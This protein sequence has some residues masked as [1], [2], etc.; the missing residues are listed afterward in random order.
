MKIGIL[1][2]FLPEKRVSLLP[3][4]CVNLIK[5][6]AEVWI[7]KD[8]GVSAF[9]SNQDYEKLGVKIVSREELLNSADLIVGI[10][11]PA[12]ADISLL[13]SSQVLIAAMNVSTTPGLLESLLSSGSTSFS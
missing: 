2:E 12:A 9:A 8:A 11:T 6:K 3:E 13:K 10:N 7:E 1:R 4:A 5:L